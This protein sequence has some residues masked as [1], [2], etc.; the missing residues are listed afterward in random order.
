M[1]HVRKYKEAAELLDRM[2]S[3]KKLPNFLTLEAYGLLA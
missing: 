1:Y 3:G 2:V